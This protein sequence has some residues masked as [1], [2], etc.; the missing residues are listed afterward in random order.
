MLKIPS[1][2]LT[3]VQL[4]PEQSGVYIWK[5]SEGEVIYVGKA[6]SLK[7]RVKSYFSD[8]PKDEKTKL[9]VNH[10]ADLDYT[11][12]NSEAEAFLLEA[13]LIKHYKPKYNVLLKD[14]K[15]YPFIKITLNEP[16]PRVLVTREVTKDGAKYFGPYTDAGSL[17]KTLRFLEWIFP[18]RNCTRK[19]PADKIIY[20]KACINHQLG[21]CLAPCIGGV[22]QSDYMK[23]VEIM[24]HFFKGMHQEIVDYFRSE[25][26]KASEEQKYELAA[27]YRDKIRELEKIAKRQTVYYPDNRN[28]DIIGFYQEQTIVIVVVLKMINGKL[29]RQENYP[30]SQTESYEPAEILASFLKLY[31]ADKEELPQEILLPLEP[32]DFSAL[33][34]WLG[35]RLFLPRRGEKAKLIAMAKRNAFNL[36][37]EQKLAHLKKAN[38]TI[39]PIQELK[40]KLNLPKLPRKI[41]CLDISTIQGSD[42]VSSAVFFLNGKPFKKNY[43]RFIIKSTVTQNDFAAMAETMS[44]YLNEIKNNP[45]LMPDLIIIDGGKGQLSSVKN[46][47]DE[48]KVKI[49]VISLAKRL[50]EVFTPDSSE[51]IILSKSSLALRLLT[52][53]RD[54][55]HRFAINFHRQRRSQRT[56]ISELEDIE[57]IGEKTKFLLLKSLGSVDAIRNATFEDLI[58]IKGIGEAT[59]T[60]IINYFA[61]KKAN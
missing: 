2:I 7:N 5:N 46:I 38:R 44:R 49:P 27:G 14:D 9:L 31:Y 32:S 24:L 10:I 23:I 33:S 1:Q 40:E 11:I 29:I 59:A 25:M 39:K 28:I 4:L 16:F 20:T 52:N 60:K 50:E 36:A 54:E 35:N 13:N 48:A 26:L 42:T 34:E 30:L 41:I 51:S 21:K 61:G 43:R 22:T 56:L 57:D 55:A 18:L 8:S 17:R 6:K 3:K 53:I 12:T 19:I 15:R 47:L 45:D 37:E 58:A